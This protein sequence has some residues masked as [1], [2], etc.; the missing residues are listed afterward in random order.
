MLVP[1]LLL[2]LL[3]PAR[4]IST[5]L[6]VPPLQWLNITHLLQGTSAPPLKY[7]SIGYDDNSR[8]LILFGGESSSGIPSSQTYL[9]VPLSFLSSPSST[10][11][12]R[13]Q[14]QH[15]V[16]SRPPPRSPH[17]PPAR[18]VHGPQWRRLLLQL[19]RLPSSP[20]SS[21]LIPLQ[22]PCPSSPRRKRLQ[23]QATVRCLGSSLP[24]PVPSSLTPQTGV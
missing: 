2:L 9:S 11:Q 13:F 12:H 21:C 1:L 5:T 14:H 19:V 18:Q 4:P 8:N 17:N 15:M 6:P 22:S 20:P 7:P 3:P 23:W 16:P 10:P 24:P